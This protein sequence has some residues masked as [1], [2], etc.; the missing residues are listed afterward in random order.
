MADL[1]AKNAALIS[2]LWCDSCDERPAYLIKGYH[3]PVCGSETVRKEVPK[4]IAFPKKQ[5]D[6]ENDSLSW[7]D[8]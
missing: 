8:G 2:V 7:L 6:P 3:C 4:E 1:K 5:I